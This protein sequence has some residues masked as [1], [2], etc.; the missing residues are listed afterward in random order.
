[1]L[2]LHAIQ[3]LALGVG[4]CLRSQDPCLLGAL[5]LS[6]LLARDGVQGGYA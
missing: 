4:V 3:A 1:M 6:A 5:Y 2:S